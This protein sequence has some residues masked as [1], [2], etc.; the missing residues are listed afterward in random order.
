MGVWP[1]CKLPVLSRQ[2][3]LL[4]TRLRGPWLLKGGGLRLLPTQGCPVTAVGL[5][6]RMAAASA[7]QE[8]SKAEGRG[9]SVQLALQP[10]C[11]LPGWLSSLGRAAF[12]LGLEGTGPPHQAVLGTV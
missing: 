7:G 2:Q 6:C 5:P 9:W 1:L 12:S 10:L 8:S 11:A 4:G 3:W